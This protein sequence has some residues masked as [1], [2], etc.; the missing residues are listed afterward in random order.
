[1]HTPSPATADDRSCGLAFLL[2]AAFASSVVWLYM[3]VGQVA[4]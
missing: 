4:R 2:V 1:M 3:L